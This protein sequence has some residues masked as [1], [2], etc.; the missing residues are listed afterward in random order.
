MPRGPSPKPTKLKLAAGNPGK[1]PLNTQEPKPEPAAGDPPAWLSD[2]ARRIWFRVAGPMTRCGLVTSADE[3]ALAR[4]C[5]LLE[6][7]TKALEAVHKA[8]ANAY[9][10]KN[11]QGRV[12]GH[13]EVPQFSDLRRIGPQL[14]QLE[15]E[16]GMTPASRTRVQLSREARLDTDD[17]AADAFFLGPGKA[18][19]SGA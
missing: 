11:K 12:T 8:G 17:D 6:L 16:F 13:R 5:S 19:A 1:R 2:G 3:L 9:S 14:T 4:Y 15:R 18:S 10:I 7:W